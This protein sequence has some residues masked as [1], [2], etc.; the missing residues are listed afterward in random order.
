MNFLSLDL[1]MAQPSGKIIQIGACVLNGDT[2]EI[3]DQRRIYVQTEEKLSAY[4]ID[5]TGITD[6]DLAEKGISLRAAY[7]QLEDVHA[8]Y[9]CFTSPV[10]W[11]G[12]DSQELRNQLESL[13]QAPESFCFGRRWLDVKTVAQTYFF[14]NNLSPQAGLAK[15][16]GK[17]GLKFI[18]RK[19][20]GMDDAVNT[21]RFYYFLVQKMKN[22]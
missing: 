9:S 20:D 4:I 16:L 15:A 10:V 12:A 5:L 22:S 21:A 13:G 17:A 14:S 2:G 8:R 3:L 6:E 1:E 19:H 18:G 7:D 11:G